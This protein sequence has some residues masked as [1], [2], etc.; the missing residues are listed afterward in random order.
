MPLPLPIRVAAPRNAAATGIS[1][2]A[3]LKNSVFSAKIKATPGLKI[4]PSVR[5]KPAKAEVRKPYTD[6]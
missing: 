5:V 1:A 3:R 6:R 2:T 4:C